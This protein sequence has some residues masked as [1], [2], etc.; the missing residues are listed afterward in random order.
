[1]GC[2]LL[3]Y[4]VM[5]QLPADGADGGPSAVR[6]EA[7][8]VSEVSAGL[9]PQF[10][11]SNTVTGTLAARVELR[12][13][14]IAGVA[15][16]VH[17]AMQLTPSSGLKDLGSSVA[18]VL[19]GPAGALGVELFPL[20]SNRVRVAFDWANT[21]SVQPGLRPAPVAVLSWDWA[22]L[23]AWFALRVDTVD[24][25]PTGALEA[26]WSTLGGLRFT[27]GAFTAEVR[28]GQVAKEPRGTSAHHQQGVS[29]QVTWSHNGGVDA[30]WDPM[31]YRTDPERF[32]RQFE[33]GLTDSRRAAWLAAE[34]G[35]VEHVGTVATGQGA[36]KYPGGYLD[37]QARVRLSRVRLFATGRLRTAGLLLSDPVFNTGTDWSQ[38]LGETLDVTA[39]LGADG[40]VSL[41]RAWLTPGLLLRLRAPGTVTLRGPTPSRTTLRS[42]EPLLESSGPLSPGM[43]V[44]QASAQA[45][46][47][48]HVAS[49]VAVALT[50]DVLSHVEVTPSSSPLRSA[51]ALRLLGQLA[52]Q[53]RL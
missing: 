9:A 14:P 48:L 45:S 44:L 49:N 23:R 30:P 18:A 50:V 20:T 25:D 28:G 3:L 16:R 47:Q 26:R 40:S 46:V 12:H 35:Y 21:W 8:A 39:M 42:V 5:T 24:V 34:A 43:T 10:V 33:R 52:V 13:E 31:T 41:G 17:G 4:V 37:L 53:G 38:P 36:L 19:H 6:A 7:T 22:K 1:M 29:A 27:R 2:G 51:A 15:L 32:E 11:G